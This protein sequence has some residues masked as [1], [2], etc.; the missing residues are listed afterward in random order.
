MSFAYFSSVTSFHIP[1]QH[2]FLLLFIA[3][4]YC[5]TAQ[6]SVSEIKSRASEGAETAAG[7]HMGEES[8]TGNASVTVLIVC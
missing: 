4:T 5:I 6:T 1:A 8:C 2:L 3:D 7:L